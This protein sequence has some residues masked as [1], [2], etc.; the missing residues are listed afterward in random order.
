MGATCGAHQGKA[1][2]LL[3][4]LLAEAA[5][6]PTGRLVWPLAHPACPDGLDAGAAGAADAP[7]EQDGLAARLALRG[8]FGPVLAA[9]FSN[10]A[11]GFKV[12]REAVAQCLA[13]VAAFDVA[14]A[15]AAGAAW[16][17]GAPNTATA[18]IESLVESVGV[19]GVRTCAG[20]CA[21][22][23]R[24]AS[25]GSGSGPCCSPGQF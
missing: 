3:K 17:D 10:L 13:H 20:A 11:H 16:G 8:A 6:L 7:A 5:A 21:R 15:A 1:I 23:C 18:I 22:S 4:P 2:A 9:L 14:C 12:V 25:R 19:L 24:P